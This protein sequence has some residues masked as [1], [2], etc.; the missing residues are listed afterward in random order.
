MSMKT[1]GQGIIIEIIVFGVV[2]MLSITI[3]LLTAET[4][5][6]DPVNEENIEASLDAEFRATQD[7]AA[8]TYILHQ[9]I[10]RH[11]ETEPEYNVTVYEVVQRYFSTEEDFKLN[12]TEYERDQ[13]EDDI[14]TFLTHEYS[15]RSLGHV[16]SQENTEGVV[17]ITSEDEYIEAW[18]DTGLDIANWHEVE[19]EIPTNSGETDLTL[20]VGRP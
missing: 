3:L 1:K 20:W 9:D 8:L 17:N 6:D 14:E 7:E 12:R 4:W 5:D 18:T 11:V 19:R 16:N 13:V 15:R 10:D 2:M